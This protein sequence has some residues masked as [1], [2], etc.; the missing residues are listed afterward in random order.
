M[1]YISE[2]RRMRPALNLARQLD[3]A[4]NPA[5]EAIFDARTAGFQIWCTPDDHP[6]GWDGVRMTQGAFSKPCEYVA[7]ICWG[8]EG[9][10][11]THLLISTDAGTLGHNQRLHNRAGDITWAMRKVR[12]LFKQASVDCPEIRIDK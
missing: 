9:E 3:I 10:R 8:W 1:S 6:K 4:T 7:S 11:I 12:R 2:H 5:P